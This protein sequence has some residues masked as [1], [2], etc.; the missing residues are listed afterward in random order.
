MRRSFTAEQKLKVIEYSKRYGARQAAIEYSLTER[1]V[2][3]WKR[4]EGTLKNYGKRRRSGGGPRAKWPE[5][6]KELKNWVVTRREERRRVNTVDIRDQAMVMAK[7]MS[8]QGLLFSSGWIFKFMK[9]NNLV[10]RQQTSVGQQ[11][12]EGYEDKTNKFR[13][14]VRNET[15]H[16]MPFNIANFDK[17]AVPFDIKGKEDI[18]ISST[19]HEKSI[20]T[21][22]LGVTAVGENLKPLVIFKCKT[23]PKDIF[24]DGVVV[25]VNEKGWMTDKLMADWINECWRK[26]NEYE[27]ENDP[28]KSLLIFD[29]A[30]CHLTENAKRELQSLKNCC[31]TW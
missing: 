7:Q 9:R 18:T 17:I 16:I 4:K 5:L 22:V 11:L 3:A 29:S 21:V 30:R 25:R 1:L 15:L 28:T 12:L 8:I 10:V 6:E 20:F 23:M 31:Y 2:R 24:N 26:K 14:F 19:G 27:N 13:N